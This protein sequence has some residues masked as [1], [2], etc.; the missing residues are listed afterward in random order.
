[1]V[2]CYN[3]QQETNTGGSLW[4]YL[5][6]TANPVGVCSL[7]FWVPDC[8]FLLLGQQG[9]REARAPVALDGRQSCLTRTPLS[10]PTTWVSGQ[11]W[12]WVLASTL[13]Q[14]GDGLSKRWGGDAEPKRLTGSHSRPLFDIERPQS[15]LPPSSQPC[16]SRA[17]AFW[18]RFTQCTGNKGETKCLA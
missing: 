2:I 3:R 10:F 1:M 17:S 12:T 14:E 5:Q 15:S 8:C 4:W 13:L 7:L 18:N 9:L 11:E 16:C 6:V